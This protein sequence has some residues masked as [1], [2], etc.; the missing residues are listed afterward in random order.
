MDGVSDLSYVF[1]KTFTY[2]NNVFIRRMNSLSDYVGG[3]KRIDKFGSMID[4]LLAQ[5]FDE[6]PIYPHFFQ[7]GSLHGNPVI[8]P[9]DYIELE[10]DSYFED[11]RHP[12]NHPNLANFKD[13]ES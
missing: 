5:I 2:F 11:D 3:T 9:H 10:F 6:Y 4:A 13:T 8:V 12:N 7:R 1:A